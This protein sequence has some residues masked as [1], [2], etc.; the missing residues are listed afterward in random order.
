MSP[1]RSN[2]RTRARWRYERRLGPS[3][4]LLEDVEDLFQTVKEYTDEHVDEAELDAKTQAEIRKS[5][6]V[7]LSAGI[8]TADSA[9][10]LRDA[11]K[12]DLERVEIESELSPIW[13]VLH[14]NLAT[15]LTW[16]D[17][18]D[19]AAERLI[20]DIYDY[21]SKKRVWWLWPTEP[22]IY[23]PLILFTLSATIFG[24]LQ[25]W[26]LTG[27]FVLLVPFLLVVWHRVSQ[28]H[29]MVVI[30][31]MTRDE[32]RKHSRETA[33]LVWIMLLSSLATGMIGFAL[34]RL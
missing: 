17:A 30:V 13:L 6:S 33:R 31:P 10:D 23:V 16:G 29:G 11:S 12:K 27:L 21:V 25:Q 2:I 20:S 4:L 18:R 15:A 9:H 7:T 24:I 5:G 32:H 14:R 19:A 26:I 28:K 1:L 8:H 34:G 22:S 3:K